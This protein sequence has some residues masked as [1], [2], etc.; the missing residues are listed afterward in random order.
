MTA[1]TVGAVGALAL[2]PV[3]LMAWVLPG[4]ADNPA[5]PVAFMAY[6][7]T[8]LGA[9]LFLRRASRVELEQL[10]GHDEVEEESQVTAKGATATQDA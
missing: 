2:A 8:A 10:A 5:F 1:R 4:G 9:P 7:A 6:I 3:A